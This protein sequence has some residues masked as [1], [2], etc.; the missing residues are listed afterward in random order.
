[1]ITRLLSSAAVLAVSSTAAMA[2]YSITILHTND[3]HSRFEPIS[4]FDSGCSEESNAEGK[5]FGGSARM[6]T[7]I[8]TM[9]RVK[10]S[11]VLAS[12]GRC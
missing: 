10:A 8:E 5:C 6:M 7:A 2:D 4:R 9:P 11:M 3:F 1:M 12:L